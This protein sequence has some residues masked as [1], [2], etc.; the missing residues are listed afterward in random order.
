MSRVITSSNMAELNCN[1]LMRHR[2]ALDTI[3]PWDLLNVIFDALYV[4]LFLPLIETPLSYVCH[5]SLL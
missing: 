1:F 5:L 4:G 2:C 3:R